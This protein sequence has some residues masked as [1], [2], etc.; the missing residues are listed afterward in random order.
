MYANIDAIQQGSNPWRTMLF[1]YQGKLLGNTLKWT[2][3]S[4]ELVTRDIR[5]VLHTQIGCTAFKG[6]WDYVP[7]MEFDGGGDR[8]WTNIMSGEWAAKEAVRVPLLSLFSS[9][10]STVHVG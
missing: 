6:H 2:T 3:Q 9:S 5:S 4:Y 10:S 1:R 7:F 8:V